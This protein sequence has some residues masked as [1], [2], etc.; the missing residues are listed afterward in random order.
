MK[1]RILGILI[2]VASAVGGVYFGVWNFFIKAI[3]DIINAV[4]TRFMVLK[5]CLALFKILF[6]SWFTISGAIFLFCYGLAIFRDDH[7]EP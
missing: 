6:G 4:G 2:M 1:D 7:S 5:I 3:I